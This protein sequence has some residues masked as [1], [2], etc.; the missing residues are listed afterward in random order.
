MLI[1]RRDFL[2]ASTVA[3]GIA[4]V[5]EVVAAGSRPVKSG[6]VT[7]AMLEQAVSFEIHPTV[8]IARVGN[9]A[10]AFYFGPE[11]LGGLP[12]PPAGF[13]DETGAMA[14]QAARFRIFAY[15]PGGKVLDRAVADILDEP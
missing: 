5:P 4:I 6:A 15:G 10:D 9:S 12:K 13:K 3:A 11:I 8:G 7:P 14:K 2:R 1:S